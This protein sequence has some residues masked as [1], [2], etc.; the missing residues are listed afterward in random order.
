MKRYLKVV[1]LVLAM[2]LLVGAI[3]MASAAT[4]A[5]TTKYSV[6]SL[7]GEALDIGKL[8]EDGISKL[9][10]TNANITETGI[11]NIYVI[12]GTTL[13]LDSLIYINEANKVSGT[14]VTFETVYPMGGVASGTIWIVGTNGVSVKVAE[15]TLKYK[16]GDVNGD[17]AIDI[18]D[19]MLTAQYA[20][21]IPIESTFI[22]GA[23]DVDGTGTIDIVDAMLIAQYAVMII[24]EFPAG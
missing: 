4:V 15:I 19:A 10:Y 8:T 9:T 22:E 3:P 14:T 16:L 21:L 11:Y 12:A 24:T 18:V 5:E 17:G 1:S 2:V 20:V 23:A 6:T 13:D 7:V